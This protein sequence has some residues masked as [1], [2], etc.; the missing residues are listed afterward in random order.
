LLAPTFLIRAI[1]I[2]H[3][4]LFSG[5][6]FYMPVIFRHIGKLTQRNMVLQVV[7]HSSL[8]LATS[9]PMFLS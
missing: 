5:L 6:V 8:L 3:L 4:E 9:A 2:N 7:S 1:F